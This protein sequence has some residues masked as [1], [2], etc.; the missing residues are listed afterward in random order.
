VTAFARYAETYG[1]DISEVVDFLE[2][3]QPRLS[4]GQL[5]R[6]ARLAPELD[7]VKSIEDFNLLQEVRAQ[8]D[9]VQR[10]RQQVA[11]KGKPIDDVPAVDR[12]LRASNQLLPLLHKLL[13]SIQNMDRLR[14]IEDAAVE[15]VKELAPDAQGRFY[16][17]LE[18]RLVRVQ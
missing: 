1:I 4:E 9:L 11:P 2:A 12:A 6:L 18:D 15:A 7:P 8:I 10:L 5:V 16:A 3:N 14:K 13:D 17:A